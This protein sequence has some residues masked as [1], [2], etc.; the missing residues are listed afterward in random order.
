MRGLRRAAPAVIGASVLAL[1][2]AACGGSS[3]NGSGGDGG[4]GAYVTGNGSEPQ[5]PLVPANTN[6]TGGGNIIDKLM[7]PSQRKDKNSDGSNRLKFSCPSCKDNA[8]G[9]PTLMLI[10]GRCQKPMAPTSQIPQTDSSEN[11]ESHAGA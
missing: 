8:W 4:S 9:K 10:C 3:D 2:L 11:Q 7:K 1:T 5:N 6:E